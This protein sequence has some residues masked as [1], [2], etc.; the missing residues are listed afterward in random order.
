MLHDDTQ[1]E[2]EASRI[3]SPSRERQREA[4]HFISPISHSFSVRRL[5]HCSVPSLYS[6]VSDDVLFITD[7]ITPFLLVTLHS[8]VSS[9]FEMAPELLR[10]KRRDTLLHILNHVINMIIT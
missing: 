1:C 3:P 5:I 10:E 8:S 2:S 4:A 7:L 9:P 6:L